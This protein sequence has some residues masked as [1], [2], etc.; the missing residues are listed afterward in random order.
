[1]EEIKV[2]QRVK[3]KTHENIVL[4]WTRL[5]GEAKITAIASE[6]ESLVYTVEMRRNGRLHHVR[7]EDFIV[8][9]TKGEA[10]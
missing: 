4:G 6:K 8:H 1:M 3:L 5:G 9:R 2:G 7:R 10:E